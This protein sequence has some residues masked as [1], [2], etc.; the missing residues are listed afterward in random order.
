MLKKKYD[1]FIEKNEIIIYCDVIICVNQMDKYMMIEI[2]KYLPLYN[3]IKLEVLSKFIK[4]LIRE[5]RWNIVVKLNEDNYLFVTCN[6]HF[7]GYNLNNIKINHCHMEYL[8]DC[9]IIYLSRSVFNFN[10]IKFLSNCETIDLSYTNIG[11]HFFENLVNCKIINLADTRV[12]NHTIKY[13][14]KCYA[15]NL[16]GNMFLKNDSMK[17]LS[18]VKKINLRHTNITDDGLQY[19]SEC[20]FID[21]AFTNIDGSGLKYLTKCK[22]IILDSCWNLD[23]RTLKYLHNC[24]YISLKNKSINSDSFKYLANVKKL[25]LSYTRTYNFH[26]EFL[27]NCESINLIGTFVGKYAFDHL[28]KFK[29]IYIGSKQ[30]DKNTIDNLKKHIIVKN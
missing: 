2:F 18:N 25:N 1:L 7:I 28:I 12:S 16:S 11:G 3:L 26:L 24:E 22:K 27:T 13:F 15:I 9:K 21:L 4:C 29:V 19:L 8:K 14:S 17:Y 5:T 10:Y 23:S 6:Y 30:L 20:E